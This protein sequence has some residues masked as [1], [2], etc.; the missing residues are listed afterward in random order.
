MKTNA[1]YI[2]EMSND[3]LCKFLMMWQDEDIDY[4]L[5]FCD[6]CKGEEFDCNDCVKSWLESDVEKHYQGL[7]YPNGLNNKPSN[8]PL[9]EV[10]DGH[11]RLIDADALLNL[12]NSCMFPSDMVTTRAVRMATNWIE[13]APTIV[14]AEEGE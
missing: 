5:T 9:V 14:P 6:L 3:E 13:D 10:P 2:R 12:V 11:G 4:S 7:K 8:C 1:D